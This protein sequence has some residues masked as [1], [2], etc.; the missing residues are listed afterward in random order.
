MPAIN[1]P[2]WSTDDLLGL[3]TTGTGPHLG[4]LEANM[5]RISMVSITGLY[6]SSV[7]NQWTWWVSAYD[8]VQWSRKRCYETNVAGDGIFEVNERTMERYQ[9]TGTCQF[10]LRGCSRSAA[11]HRI[12]RWFYME[13]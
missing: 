4:E 5:R 9:I 8:H 7:D 3:S 10:S 6:K 2:E 12:V 13:V 1:A 11:Y